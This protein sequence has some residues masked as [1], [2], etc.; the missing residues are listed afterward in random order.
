MRRVLHILTRTDD[1]LAR[2]LAARQ[3]NA[4]GNNVETVDLTRPKPDYKDL[5]VKIFEA[6]SIES[7]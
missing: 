4:A 5:L 3:R 1:A 6:D 7:W 2:E